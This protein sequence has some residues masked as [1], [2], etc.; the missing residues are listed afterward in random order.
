MDMEGREAREARETR[1]GFKARLQSES[2]DDYLGWGV[3]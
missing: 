3:V 1:G 2:V